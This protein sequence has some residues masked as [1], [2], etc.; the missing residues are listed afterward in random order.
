MQREQ[1]LRAWLDQA[2]KGEP[3]TLAPA[4]ADASFR[5][6]F[7]VGLD[8]RTLIAMDAPPQHEDCRPF[9]TVAALFGGAGV[10]VPRVLAQDLAQRPHGDGLVALGKVVP[11]GLVHHGLVARAGFLRAR[12]IRRGCRCR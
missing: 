10:H 12:G 6:Y 2:L 9:V 4:S 3:Y 1:Q 8:K 5:R 11:Q 7:R